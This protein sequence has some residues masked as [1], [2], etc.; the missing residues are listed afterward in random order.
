MIQ[1]GSRARLAMEALER[2]RIAGEFLRQELERHAPAQAQ[3]LGLIH[4]AHAAAAQPLQ[5]A[6]MR[7]RLPRRNHSAML[8]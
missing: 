4:H 8:W 6:I 7:N 2:M 5:H 3:V 1:G